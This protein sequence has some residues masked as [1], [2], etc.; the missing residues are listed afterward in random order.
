MTDAEIEARIEELF[1]ANHR[2]ILAE[3]GA[4]V[5]TP[6]A[7][8]QARQQVLHYWRK[9]RDVA[10]NVTETEVHLQLPNQ[11]TPKGRRFV[12]EG[13]VDLVREGE[14]LRM[15]DI[16]THH[17]S[18]VSRHRDAYAAQLNVYAHLWHRLRDQVIHDLGVIA[19]QLPAELQRAIH[20]KDQRRINQQLAAWNP[21]VSIPADPAAIAKTI[22][23]IALTVDRIEDGVFKPRSAQELRAAGRGSGAGEATFAT[24]HCRNCDGRF[25]CRPYQQYLQTDRE[26]GAEDVWDEGDQAEWLDQ[27]SPDEDDYQ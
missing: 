3:G 5:L 9:L 19:I 27:I 15:Y 26:G 18:E 8:A 12:I 6:Q 4:H 16:K 11:T 10:V 24:L 2:Q 22:Q 13:V 21:L 25:S 20:D 1:E 7:L 17:C 23:N 14:R